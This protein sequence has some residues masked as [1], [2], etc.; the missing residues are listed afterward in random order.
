MLGAVSAQ[1]AQFRV[2]IFEQSIAAAASTV[3]KDVMTDFLYNR[4]H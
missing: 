2:L 1:V 3:A 4:V